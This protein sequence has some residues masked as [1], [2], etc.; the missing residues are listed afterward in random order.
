M[1]Y[2]AIERRRPPLASEAARPNLRNG[3]ALV[4]VAVARLVFSV[5]TGVLLRTMAAG[6][7]LRG[8]A[9]NEWLTTSTA[10]NVIETLDHPSA[11]VRRAAYDAL[12]R[13]TDVDHGEHAA[14]WR[15]SGW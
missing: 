11:V 15:A 4:E 2:R 12:R 3:V 1:S 8:R 7:G 9:Q 10:Q 6:H 13:A 14:D 5:T